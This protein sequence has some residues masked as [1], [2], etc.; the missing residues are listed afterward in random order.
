M[1]RAALSRDAEL[2][3]SP[4]AAEPAAAAAAA[5][6]ATLKWCAM[7]AKA[8]A[9]SEGTAGLSDR[10]MSLRRPTDSRALN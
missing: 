5:A 8:V 2:S 6:E 3:A 4:V 9:S 7:K 1:A 10:K